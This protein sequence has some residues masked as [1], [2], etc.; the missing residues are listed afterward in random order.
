[1][2]WYGKLLHDV[3][4][5]PLNCSLK[6]CILC[7]VGALTL[8]HDQSQLHFCIRRLSA[9]EHFHAFSRP[10]RDD[11]RVTGS[12]PRRRILEVEALRSRF[13]LLVSEQLAQCHQ[14][15]NEIILW[16]QSH[17]LHAVMSRYPE[18]PGMPHA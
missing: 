11:A 4:R 9:D 12:R 7:H 3:H 15:A 10:Y 5:S 8:R 1:M 2:L 16:F 6:L 17:S 14:R 18:N 13:H